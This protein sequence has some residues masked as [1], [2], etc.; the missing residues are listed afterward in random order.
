[1]ITTPADVELNVRWDL[2]NPNPSGPLPAGKFSGTITVS[3]NE[4]GNSPQTAV[5]N[6]YSL[7]AAPLTLPNY[8]NLTGPFPRS[9]TVTVTAPTPT[10]FTVS[11][12]PSGAWVTIS[13]LAATTP[14]TLVITQTL[15]RPS[16]IPSPEIAT[17][18]ATV[19]NL[20]PVPVYLSIFD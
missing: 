19:E 18:Y 13:P 14:A 15:A 9:Q 11:P 16:T 17:L 12:P 8:V 5:V 3:S 10:T 7:T 1:M 4:A 20:P 2:L 6:A